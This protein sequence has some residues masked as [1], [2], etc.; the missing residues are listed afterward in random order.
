MVASVALVTATLLFGLNLLLGVAVQERLVDTSGVRW[1][2]HGLFFLVAASA[3]AAVALGLLT[4]TWGV[5]ALSPALAAYVVLPRTRGGTTRHRRLA[6]GVVP[7][8]ALALV[9][10]V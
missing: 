5:L 9:L 7:F 3:V 2:H 1:V 6:L 4:R 8:Y 10:V